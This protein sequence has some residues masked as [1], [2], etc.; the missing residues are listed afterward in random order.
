MIWYV[1]RENRE[2]LY[3]GIRGRFKARNSKENLE[4]LRKM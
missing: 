2:D 4:V 1:V 3:V